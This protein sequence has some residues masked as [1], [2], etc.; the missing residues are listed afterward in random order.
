MSSISRRSLAVSA[1]A[2]RPSAGFS[3][4]SSPRA[5]GLRVPSAA[6]PWRLPAAPP[7]ADCRGVG[8]E[9]RLSLA[10]FCT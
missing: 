1:V 3:F 5:R 4:R 2:E 6:C 9:V 8:V 10:M 7:L